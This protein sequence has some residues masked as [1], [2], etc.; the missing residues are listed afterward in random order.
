MTR[1]IHD[2]KLCP[3]CKGEQE[4]DEEPCRVCD[5]TGIAPG[6]LDG[7]TC[8][9]QALAVCVKCDGTGELPAAISFGPEGG[10]V[11]GGTCDRCN[12]SGWEPCE[13]CSEGD[14]E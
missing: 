8:G 4:V 3:A 10:F 6:V 5:A 9:E 14:S 7:C 1:A 12:G 13:P 11:P 2:F